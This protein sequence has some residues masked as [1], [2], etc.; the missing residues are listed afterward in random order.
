M[1]VGWWGYSLI[2]RELPQFLNENLS[3]ALGRPIKVGQFQRFNLGGVRLGPAIVPPTEDDFSWVKAQYLDVKFNPIELLL[4]RTL[5]PTLVFDEPQMALKQGFNGEWKV[6]PPESV[7]QRGLIKTELESLQI[8]NA[9]LAIGP[10]SRTSIVEAPEGVTSATLILLQNVN[11]RVR[12][13]GADNQ[14][15]SLIV[16]GRLNNGSF[17]LRGEGQ[18]DTRQTNLM[19][20]AQQLPIEA[21][22]PLAGGSLFVR[23]GL[24]STNLDL[25]YRPG[26]EDPLIAKGTA[27]LRNG[28]IVITG[29]PSPF[30]AINGTAVIDGVGG[31]LQNS[32]LKFGPILVKADG[33]VDLHQGHN[34]F[35]DIPEVSVSDLEQAFAQ[36]LPID[37]A[38]SFRVNTHITGELT[39]P[40]VSGD[41]ANL[42]PVRIDRLGINAIAAQFAANLEGFTL[43][44]ATVRPAT[45]GTV[46]AQGRARFRRPDLRRPDLNFT[47]QTDLPLDGIAALY[48]VP[49]PETIRL[50]PL[51]AAAR[52]TGQPDDLR[53]LADWQLPQASFPGR[54]RV[55]YAN[56][57]VQ[58]ENARFQVGDGT[59]QASA[60][61]DL[62]SLDWQATLAGSALGLGRLSPQLRGTLDANLRAV[63]NLTA[64][65]PQGM[66]A[67]G[68]LRLSDPVPLTLARLEGV[69]QV[70]PGPL[71]ARFAWTGQRL[72]V[73]EATAPNL[74]V[75]GGADVT[76]PAGG[77]LPDISG[78]DFAA[79]L[80]DF[81]IAAAYALMDGPG[82]LRPQG[83][84][85]FDGSLRGSLRDPR[86]AG[87]AG[88]RG[89]AVND[90]ALL[91]DVS[92]PIRAS[93][94]EGV[95]ID[96]RGG[97]TELSATIDPSLRPNAFR[98]TNGEFVAAGQR[99]GDSLNA[100]I[101]NFDLG[102]LALR[103]GEILQLGPDLG[104]VG[105]VLNAQAR[106]NLAERLNPEIA[107]SFAIADPA[108]GTIAADSFSGRLQYRDGLALLT[109]GDLQ[110]TPATQFRLTANGRL[111][112]EWQAEAEVTTANAEFQDLLQVLSLYS[113][114][115][116]GNLLNPVALGSA[117]DLDVHSVGVPAAPLLAQAT[118]AQALRDLGE[119]QA[120]QLAEALLPALDQLE[121][122]VS[123]R[124][125]VNASQRG[126]LAADFDFAGQ[127][128][129]WG[130]Y[131]F[132]NQFVAQG[133][134]R[135]QTLTL[136]PVEFRAADTRL[137]LVGDVSLTD[138]DLEIMAAAL[139]LT[140]AANLLASPLEVTGL[141]NLDANLTG[142]YTNPQ[143]VGQLGVDGASIN[144]QPIQEISSTFKYQDAYVTVDGRV[145]G[146]SPEPLLFAGRVPYALPFM[147]VQP[148]SDEL[149]L[150]AMLKDDALALV[151]LFTPLLVWGGGDANIDVQ[152]GGTLSRPLVFGVAAFDGATFTSPLLDASLTGLT[153]EVQLQGTRIAVPSLQ[154]NV[155]DGPFELSGDLPLISKD[156]TP[157]DKGLRLALKDIDVNF[158]NEVR[159]HVNGYL[160]VTHAVLAPTLGGE[161]RLQDTRVVV[162]SALRGLANLTLT[163]PRIEAVRASLAEGRQ[164][165]PVQ[166]DHL[167]IALEPAT[168]KAL[169]LFSFD[170]EGALAVSGQIPGLYADGHF[171]LTDGWIQ[172]ITA[173]FFLEPGRD[174]VIV[175]SPADQL[176]PYLDL[177]LAATVPLQRNYNLASLNT[178]TGS[179]EI[180]DPDLLASDTIFD[181][182]LIEAQVKGPATRLFDNL[183]LTSN[184]PYSEAQLLG[185]A[186]GGYLSDLSGTEPALALGSNL[187]SA[188]FGD[189]Q[190]SIG[191]ALGL[192]RF[193][194][195]ASTALP[196]DSG[197][198]LGYGVGANLGITENLSARLVQ[199]LNQNQPIEFNVRY[200][201]D[202]NW[203]VHGS[204]NFNNDNR[205]SVEYRINF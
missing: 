139:P 161:V 132:D 131:D 25:K 11:M 88:L 29:L 176:D 108:L 152:V 199:V 6:Q 40:Q 57:V 162:G 147:T 127:N 72:E 125:G 145:V 68:E 134:L 39:A 18:L 27:R 133:Q 159:S 179:A 42:D 193:R 89:V 181:E 73:P 205:L 34:L 196:A 103:P 79:R 138:S 87:T 183:V 171:Y 36:A 60:T 123:G 129:A 62:S 151:N 150:K 93:Q 94:G 153:G 98:L 84:V 173:E 21:I 187:V 169:P 158:V 156:I 99:Q 104:S 184:P 188:L 106:I 155:F 97:R 53:G 113:Y 110:L 7:G 76:F 19:V 174:N 190:D 157:D 200:R 178:T 16:G 2:R 165:L 116:L 118:L 74:Y 170:L 58:A 85:N 175:F 83:W 201:I 82:W 69:D 56:Q 111:F 96:L 4:T 114:A 136:N 61:A 28:D 22:N 3:D 185:M 182:L 163:S 15:A 63:G 102:A 67:E 52:V 144:Q 117:V 35:I 135:N 24:L 194:L 70:L 130:R 198:T 12:F 23:N 13:G 142:P 112:P 48:G 101:S 10:I 141:L 164:V 90:L 41:L 121:G 26:A 107:A 191:D 143:L 166:V 168:V 55:T 149:A 105:G 167:R 124:L 128:W 154:G 120:N 78:M 180:P 119:L 71:R 66:R 160:T 95:L 9:N 65:T 189:T 59:L 115:D 20:Q 91:E 17:Q 148:A 54:G 203:G 5:R 177:V 45:G 38:G 8:R 47:A 51:L 80:S 31:R 204:T 43:N 109:G 86:L 75:S 32:S 14:T 49:L 146:P 140:A 1:V 77:G 192:K 195:S 30:Q 172:T 50:G 122:Q 197:D 64:I 202:N 46:T 44:Q 137:S 37:A 126:G 92:G 81:N 186:S 100:E 33:R